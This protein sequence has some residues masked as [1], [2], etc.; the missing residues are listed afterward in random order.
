[1]L[2]ALELAPAWEA[3]P[4]P[5]GYQPDT[6]LLSDQTAKMYVALHRARELDKTD[7]EARGAAFDAAY[8]SEAPSEE[9]LRSVQTVLQEPGELSVTQP[10]CCRAG[11]IS[12]C[13]QSCRLCCIWD[14][15]CLH[16]CSWACCR[17]SASKGHFCSAQAVLQHPGEQPA[18][19]LHPSC[20]L[21]GLA[22]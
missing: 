4:Q 5:S 8:G 22:S 12:Q 10:P 19:L 6:A 2:A 14:S 11:R 15:W 16:A 17:C 9:Q 21:C 13:Q 3:K 18:S 20:R 7:A 1:M